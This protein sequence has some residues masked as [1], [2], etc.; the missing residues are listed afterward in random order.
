MAMTSWCTNPMTQNNKFTFRNLDPLNGRSGDAVI[1]SPRKRVYTETQI[2][3][4]QNAAFSEGVAAGE[5]ATLLRIEKKTEE[6]LELLQ[7][8]YASMI[9]EV[10]RGMQM[11]R[12]EAAELALLIA[13]KLSTALIE[14]QPLV[15]I[16]QL[17]NSCIAHLNAEPRIVIRVGDIL[18]DPLKDKIEGLARKAG[19]PGRIVIIGEPDALAAQTQIEWPDGGVNYRSPEMIA[20]IDKLI[21][22][23]ALSSKVRNNSEFT[24]HHGMNSS[25]HDVNQPIMEHAQ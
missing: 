1:S 8:H 19:Y 23:Y 18:V 25:S 17:F 13:Q 6:N 9:S 20:H 7:Q 12:A 21:S 5:K 3:E 15:E 14:Q 22:D 2:E 11:L 16:E 10:E 4:I 24:L